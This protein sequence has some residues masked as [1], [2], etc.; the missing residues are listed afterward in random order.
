MPIDTI[1]TLV[2]AYVLD[3]VDDLERPAVERHLAGCQEC[4]AEVVELRE[5]V[6]QFAASA[7]V[8][9]PP[10]LRNRVLAQVA[11]TRQAAPGRIRSVRVGGSGR[12]H[13]GVAMGVAACLLAVGGGA[14]VWSAQ[15]RIALE[16]ASTDAAEQRAMEA[17]RR[18]LAIQEVLAAPD[19][20]VRTMKVKGGGQIVVVAS[21]VQD[22]A[23][24]VV[25]DLRQMSA[26]KTY[27]LWVVEQAKPRSAGVLD[28]GTTEVTQLVTGLRKAQKLCLTVEPAGG[29]NQPTTSP[30]VVVDL[31]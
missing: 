6:A 7:A 28:T 12:W 24:V 23:V 14:A 27:Q 30:V 9:P 11:R 4:A 19:A 17:E 31:E 18:E 1:H 22:Q 8:E 5:A 3:A 29:S 25:S 20:R 15:Q 13:R 10:G 2:G 21:L 26:D 16:Q